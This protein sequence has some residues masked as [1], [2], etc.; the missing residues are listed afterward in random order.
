MK[1][2]R[3]E[4]DFIEADFQRA[5]NFMKYPIIK[6]VTAD[7]LELYGILTEAEGE[8]DAV[9]INIHGTSGCF[10]VEEYTPFFAEELPALGIATLFTNNRGSHVM[11]A[12]QKSGAALEMFEDCVLDIDA[13]IQFA[14]HLG[15]RRI[16]L[17]GHSLGTEKV[18]YYMNKGKYPPAVAAVI[19]LGV[20]DSFGNQARIAK[21]FPADP[22]A[23]AKRLMAEGKGEHFLTSVWRP[24]GGAVPQSAASY[25]N[26]FSPG[27]ELS[28][29][30]PLRQRGDLFFYRAIRV[31]ILVAV[32][33]FDPF[34]CIPVQEALRLLEK[35]NPRTR[36][37]LVAG[38]DHEFSGKSEEL[39]KIVKYFLREHLADGSAA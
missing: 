1:P 11:E 10:Y 24:H 32:G 19:L 31:P 23:E 21:G 2:D 37:R 5:G 6:T 35:E 34:T 9:L 16:I 7:H 25:L 8:K 36:T 27:S 14:L 22:M 12:W 18:V 38:A 39:L 4:K 26:F 30:I 17:Q 33:E 20:S 3:G 28:K 13:W 29:A 15:Y